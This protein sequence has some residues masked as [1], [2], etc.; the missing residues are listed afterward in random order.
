[1]NQKLGKRKCKNQECGILF[2]KERPLQS[3]CSP[4]CAY[5]HAKKIR[6]KQIDKDIME[7]K[8]EWYDKNKTLGQYERDARRAFQKWVRMRD[9]EH[10]CISCGNNISVRYDGGH[11]LDANKYSGLIF[12]PD[13]CHKQCSRPCNKD[14][15]GDS[16]NYRI[17]LVERIGEDKVKW[18]EENKDRLRIYKYTKEELLKIKV[19]F[20]LKIKQLKLSNK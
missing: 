19:T 7:E 17:G 2:Q 16:I 10:G 3:C 20:L 4:R 11:Y 5:D 8:K 13:N 18:L 9:E 12:H 1:M 14:K 6:Q 15:H